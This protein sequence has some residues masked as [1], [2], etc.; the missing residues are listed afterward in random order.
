MPEVRLRPQARQD[1]LELWVYIAKEN[2]PAADRLLG[3]IDSALTLLSENPAA[4]RQRPELVIGLRSFPVG[5]YILFYRPTED[6][7][8][9]V[10][11]LHGYRD[12][13]S[14]LLT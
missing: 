1:V 6:G 5:E 4:G 12:I 11:V 8:D 2:E 10:R 7:I 9:L 14:N 3:R 13:E